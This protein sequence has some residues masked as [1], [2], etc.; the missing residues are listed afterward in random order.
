MKKFEKEKLRWREEQDRN[1]EEERDRLLQKVRESVQ[2]EHEE[3]ER[4]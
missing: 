1:L 3:R 4:G 2:K